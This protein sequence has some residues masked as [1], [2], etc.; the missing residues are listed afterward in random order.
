[1]WLACCG[2]ATHCMHTASDGR[3]AV[4]VQ[5][6]TSCSVPSGHAAR[7]ATAPS[8]AP[9]HQPLIWRPPLAS[10]LVWARQPAYQARIPNRTRHE[11][12]AWVGQRTPR[13]LAGQHPSAC[14]PGQARLLA[15]ARCQLGYHIALPQRVCTARH[16][17]WAAT[18]RA[19]GGQRPKSLDGSSAA[20]PLPAP[21]PHPCPACAAHAGGRRACPVGHALRAPPHVH[22]PSAGGHS[23]LASRRVLCPTLNNLPAALL[24]GTCAG[25]PALRLHGGAGWPGVV[26]AALPL[27][28]AARGEGERGTA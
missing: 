2:A 8:A 9:A 21:C 3:C 22:T 13:L 24:A 28:A 14:A 17:R 27:P 7:A 1:M 6:S 20:S 16:R 5:P 4:V 18:V 10:M 23:P 19:R 26:A 11:W 15:A 12:R 25:P